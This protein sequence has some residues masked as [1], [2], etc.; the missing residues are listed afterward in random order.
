M[1]PHFMPS[2]ANE[3][4]A[5]PAAP[6][7]LS[8]LEDHLSEP[9]EAVINELADLDGDMVILGA[10]GKMGPALAHMAQRA[11]A[12]IG[13]HRKVI[14]VSRFSRPGV[15]EQLENWGITTHCCDLLQPEDTERLPNAQLVVSMS[16]FKFGSATQ[17]DYS[18]ATNCLVPANICQRYRE[19][20]VVAFSSGN[21]YGLTSVAQGGS[22]ESD[23]LDPV[24]EYSMAALGRERIYEFCSRQWDIPTAIL[25]LNYATEL[26]YGV[27][28][29][30]AHQVLGNKTIDLTMGHVNVIWLRDANAMTLRAFTHAQSPARTI[31]VA[32][33][34][35]IRVR[36]AADIFARRFATSLMVT[37]TESDQAFLNNATDAY[38]LLGRPE[39][40]A[41]QMI[42][43]TASWVAR[44][45]ENAGK[46][47][48]FQVLNGKY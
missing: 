35:I 39:H 1:L 38:S 33:D 22:V 25:R 37:G 5:L 27:L 42:E 20:R 7:S 3:S 45:G 23:P 46:P 9:P 19:S 34:E 18:W 47:T 28:V 8:E 2:V 10:G 12:A 11:F 43:W 21:V 17:P 31:N 13:N 44:G 24:G 48:H 36:D 41:Q 29:D 26:R 32:G 16:G 4:A 30:L 14:A 40:S 6:G 15:R